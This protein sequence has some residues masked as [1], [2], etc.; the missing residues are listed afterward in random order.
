MLLYAARNSNGLKTKM[1]WSY[2]SCIRIEVFPVIQV[3]FIIRP[4]WQKRLKIFFK[5]SFIPLIEFQK[6]T[7]PCNLHLGVF[8]WSQK[9]IVWWESW[10]RS[11]VDLYI[12]CSPEHL[13]QAIENHQH[14]LTY[15]V[16]KALT[17]LSHLFLSV[18]CIVFRKVKSYG[19][20]R[21]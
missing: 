7:N 4:N 15:S 13:G 16:Q 3:C 11:S 14:G 18:C 6:C 19:L 17:F 8:L 5:S 2:F 1:W 21:K 20:P 12:V 10:K 9:K